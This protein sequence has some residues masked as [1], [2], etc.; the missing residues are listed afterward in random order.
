MVPLATGSSTFIIR[1]RLEKEVREKEEGG[2][3]RERGREG[4]GEG[5]RERGRTGEGEEMKAHRFF[6]FSR[7]LQLILPRS[8][9]SALLR[10]LL[11]SRR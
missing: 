5:G 6:L 7:L 11:W 3:K 2:R 8:L 4:E 9:L 10:E 1:S